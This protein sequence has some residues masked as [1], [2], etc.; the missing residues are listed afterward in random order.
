MKMLLLYRPP[1]HHDPLHAGTSPPHARA[2]A[3]GLIRLASTLSD[4]R[5]SS[6][7]SISVQSAKNALAYHDQLVNSC[8]GWA[9]SYRPQPHAP[10]GASLR[11]TWVGTPTT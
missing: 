2:S 9:G 5:A 3:E 11:Y 7:K 4:P 1:Y 8:S 10:V 6:A